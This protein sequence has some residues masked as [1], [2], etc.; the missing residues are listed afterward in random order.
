MFGILIVCCLVVLLVV[1][2]GLW[3]LDCFDKLIILIT[4]SMSINAEWTKGELILTNC[5]SKC[6]K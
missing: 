6:D 3:V 4:V 5:S 1:S 2:F